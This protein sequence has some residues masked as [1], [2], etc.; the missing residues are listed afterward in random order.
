MGFLKEFREFAIKGNVMDMAIGI[1]IGAAFTGVVN[2]LVNDVIMPPLGVLISGIDFSSYSITLKPE[3][4]EAAPAA[5]T[6]APDAAPPAATPKPPAKKKS[7]AVVLAYGKFINTV[8]QFTIV[9]F[10]VFLIVKQINRLKR[11][12]T[13]APPQTKECPFC[14]SNIAI[15]AVRCPNCTSQLQPA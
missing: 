12:S 14:A 7:P 6:A 10:V 3:V 15:K 11:S 1:I 8:I 2:S 4:D 5:P 13:P 9:A